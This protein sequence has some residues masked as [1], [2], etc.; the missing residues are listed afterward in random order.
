MD[1]LRC[2]YAGL[3]SVIKL[4]VENPSTIEESHGTYTYEQ[5]MSSTFK[6]VMPHQHYVWDSNLGVWTDKS[7]DQCI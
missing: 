5:L 7:D 6:L 3:R 4:Q 1:V 2:A